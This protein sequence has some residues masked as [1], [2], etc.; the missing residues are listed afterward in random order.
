MSFDFDV[1]SMGGFGGMEA[2]F[3]DGAAAA[4]AAAAASSMFLASRV[5]SFDANA[6][7]VAAAS[8]QLQLLAPDDPRQP[9]PLLTEKFMLKHFKVRTERRSE[10]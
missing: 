4:A 10:R 3:G 7:A 5:E 8:Q 9:Q 1:A 2:P 6:A